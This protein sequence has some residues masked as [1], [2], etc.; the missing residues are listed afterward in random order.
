MTLT[1]NFPSSSVRSR[2]LWFSQYF[3][4]KVFL[5]SNILGIWPKKKNNRKSLSHYGDHLYKVTRFWSLHC[6][7][8][9]AHKDEE[10]DKQMERWT[11]EWTMPYHKMSHFWWAYKERS[12]HITIRHYMSVAIGG[13]F[14]NTW[15]VY[16]VILG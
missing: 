2:C 1:V 9:P 3:A 7:L 15:A 11:D 6:G 8:Y 12:L 14:H 4:Y 5:L 16:R 13:E 10:M